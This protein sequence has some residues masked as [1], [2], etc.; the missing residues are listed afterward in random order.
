MTCIKGA[1]CKCGNHW[2]D[3]GRCTNCF[4]EQ[5]TRKAK[6]FVIWVDKSDV[7]V[8]GYLDK[9]GVINGDAG[10]VHKRLSVKLKDALAMY[11]HFEYKIEK[12]FL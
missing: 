12:E 1:I 4:A 2:Y 3:A 8:F 7:G 5:K 10:Y 11:E 6:A 9:N